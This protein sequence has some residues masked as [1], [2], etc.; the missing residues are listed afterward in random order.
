M[1][2][3]RDEDILCSLQVQTVV[4]QFFTMEWLWATSLNQEKGTE[5]LS[6]PLSKT[7]QEDELSIPL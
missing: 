4:S 5:N 2:D 1:E 7:M 3:M 6:L